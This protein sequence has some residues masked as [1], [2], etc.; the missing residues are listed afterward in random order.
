[1]LTAVLQTVL[2]VTAAVGLIVTVLD[3]RRGSA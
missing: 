3:I 2:I 1:M